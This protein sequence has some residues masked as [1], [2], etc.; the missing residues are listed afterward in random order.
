MSL[1]TAEDAKELLYDTLFWRAYC[2][3]ELGDMP[4]MDVAIEAQAGLAQELQQPLY[5][6]VNIQFRAMRALLA[7]RFA[8]SER[9]AQEALAIGQRL[10]TENVAGIFGLQMFTL[11]R[12]Q[13]AS[14]NWNPPCGT[15]SSD[16][17]RR[18][19]GAPAWR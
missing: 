14:R 12:E 7:G 10:R 16:T 8:D 9:L 18:P 17:R 6:C 1:A 11:R 5:L 4:A 19:P 2:L 3:L 13:D 15:L